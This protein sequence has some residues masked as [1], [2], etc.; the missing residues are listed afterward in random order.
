MSNEERIMVNDLTAKEVI[1]RL[2]DTAFK[3]CGSGAMLEKGKDKEGLQM[4]NDFAWCFG[5]HLRIDVVE[6]GN[7][8]GN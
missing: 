8:G 7:D 1:D 3:Y 2:E 5:M 6:G 4:I